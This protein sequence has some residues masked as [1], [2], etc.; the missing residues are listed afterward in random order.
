MQELKVVTLPD[1]VWNYLLAYIG[2]ETSVTG[3]ELLAIFIV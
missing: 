2:V 3:K 1:V